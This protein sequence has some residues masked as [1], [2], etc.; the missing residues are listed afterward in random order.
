MFAYLR[1]ARSI[2]EHSGSPCLLMYW[3]LDYIS[4][5]SLDHYPIRESAKIT[6]CS[7]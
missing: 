3:L 4:H 1:E 7:I 6:I 5:K 2:G